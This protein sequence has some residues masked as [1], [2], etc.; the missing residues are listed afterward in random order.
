MT[1]DKKKLNIGILSKALK[2]TKNIPKNII[3]SLKDSEDS[4]VSHDLLQTHRL[5][6]SIASEDL[7]TLVSNIP[8]GLAGKDLLQQGTL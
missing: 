7:D 3:S 4:Q 8:G 1:I 6:V 2:G 5:H